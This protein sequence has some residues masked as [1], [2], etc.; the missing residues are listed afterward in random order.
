MDYAEKTNR[1]KRE[2]QISCIQQYLF[3]GCLKEKKG[4]IL[5]FHLPMNPRVHPHPPPP[6]KPKEVPLT[7]L[8]GRSELSGV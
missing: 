4:S 6:K 8:C 2:Q 7:R 1:E 3:I 5:M